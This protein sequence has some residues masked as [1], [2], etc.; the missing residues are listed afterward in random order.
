VTNFNPVRD[1]DIDTSELLQNCVIDSFCGAVTFCQNHS[2]P[3]G[4]VQYIPKQSSVSPDWHKTVQ[5]L[6]ENLREAPVFQ[7]QNGVLKSLSSLRYLSPEHYG[8]DNQPLFGASDDEHYLSTK[9][10]AYLDFLKPLG[11]QE[12]SDHEVLERLKPILTTPLRVLPSS[13]LQKERISLILRLLIVWLKRDPN[14]TLA[15]EIRNIPVIELS[16]GSFV[17]GNDLNLTR[18]EADLAFA[19]DA[20]Y[21]PTDSNGNDLPKCLGI[22]TVSEEAVSDNDQKELFRL[23]GVRRASPELVMGLITRHSHATSFVPTARSLI[24]DF[25]RIL[26]YVYDSCAKDDRLKTPCLIVFDEHCLRRP[27]CRDSCPRYIPS[28]IYLRTDGAYG[29]EAIAK[30]L[31]SGSLF[32]PRLRLLHPAFLYPKL[33]SKTQMANDTWRTWLEQQ[34]ITRRVP[35]LTHWNNRKQLSELFNTIISHH[36]DILLGVLGRYWDTYGTEIKEDPLIASAIKGAK[37]PTSDGLARLDECYF[38]IPEICNMVEAVSTT[39]NIKFLKL[40]GIWDLDS[41]QEWG[42]LRE[43]GVSGGGAA[44]FI[45]VVKDRL[46]STMTLEGAKPHFFELYRWISERLSDDLWYDRYSKCSDLF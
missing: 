18:S 29:T 24:A 26:C 13:N 40:P 38:P 35:R 21:F 43:L 14:S 2:L 30:R 15:T 45:M 10:S 27:V 42:F 6:I 8:A 17:R 1:V 12:V 4:W 44:T 11:L 5:G 16:N 20:V 46:L 7:S 19:N 23:L 31:D 22:L 25:M 28:D 37:V 41:E 9:Y 3:Y 36:P 33:I 39:L 32:S 34:G